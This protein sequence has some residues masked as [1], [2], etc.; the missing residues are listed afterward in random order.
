MIKTI[1]I[2]FGR[3]IAASI[4]FVSAGAYAQ[5]EL[6]TVRIFFEKTQKTASFDVK[7]AGSEESSYEMDVVKWNVKGGKQHSRIVASPKQFT[8]KP[9][10]SQ[11]VRFM[12][13][14][15][16]DHPAPQYFRAYLR[17]KQNETIELKPGQVRVPVTLALPIYFYDKQVQPSL[18]FWM[19]SIA[20]GKAGNL[21]VENMGNQF[22]RIDSVFDENGH[23]LDVNRVALPG[24]QLKVLLSSEKM[25]SKVSLMGG[26]VFGL[27]VK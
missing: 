2:A 15:S 23:K 25:P 10:Q 20:N 17:E 19:E 18:N 26:F 3:L 1:L 16:N 13:I 22:I 9:G 5:V 21:V 7:N 6:S 12:I 11:K 24:E 14:G 8:L 27:S 4:L